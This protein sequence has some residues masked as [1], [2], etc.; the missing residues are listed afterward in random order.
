MPL[1]RG[2]KDATVEAF[3]NAAQLRSVEA[4]T[5]IFREGEPSDGMCVILTGKVKIT[6]PG[7]DGRE[8][9]YTIAGPGDMLG[10]L[11]VFDGDVRK[12]TAKSVN[13]VTLAFLSNADVLSW[14]EAY[15]EA[16]RRILRMLVVRLRR[17]NDALADMYGLD[18]STRVARAILRLSRRFGRKTSEGIRVDLD[19]SQEE[20]ALHVRA[21][22][23]SVNQALSSFSRFGWIRREGT[24]VVILDEDALLRQARDQPENPPIMPGI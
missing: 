12:A 21:S 18:V 13:A 16:S 14:L 5:E 19:L 10:E 20:L 2:L 11:S 8:N 4:Q 24:E 1:L 22:R 7:D 23:E 15:P 3:A 9:I 6:R 17:Q